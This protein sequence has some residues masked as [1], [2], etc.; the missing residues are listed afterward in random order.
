MQVNSTSSSAAALE[1][2]REIMVM[3]KQQ[4]VTKEV[5][6]ALVE[7]VKDTPAPAPGRIDT[8]A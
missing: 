2:Q 4:D 5:G 1:A 7:L 8:Y 6:Q 3:K